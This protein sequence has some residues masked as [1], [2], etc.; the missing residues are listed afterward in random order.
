[1]GEILTPL[2]ATY[3]GRVT[4]LHSTSSF[5]LASQQKRTLLYQTIDPQDDRFYGFGPMLEPRC[6]VG[7]E[8]LDQ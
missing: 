5:D 6:I 3:A 2:I 4:S 8:P 1:M 7:P